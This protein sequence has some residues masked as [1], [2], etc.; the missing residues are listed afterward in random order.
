LKVGFEELQENERVNKD[1]LEELNESGQRNH[2]VL[3]E[4]FQLLRTQT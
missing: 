1:L 2:D 3:L 4:E